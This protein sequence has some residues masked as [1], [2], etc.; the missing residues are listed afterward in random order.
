MEDKTIKLWDVLT[1]LQ[2][3]Y[4]KKD[5]TSIEEVNSVSWKF[6]RALYSEVPWIARRSP[7]DERRKS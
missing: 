3:R 6:K 1:F 7:S 4:D 2:E 5:Y